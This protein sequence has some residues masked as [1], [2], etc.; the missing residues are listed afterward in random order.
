MQFFAK[1]TN[2]DFMGKRNAALIISIALMLASIVLLATRGLSFGLDFT[3]GTLI[4]AGYS[5]EADLS[6]LR[7][8]LAEAGY[9]D[10]VVQHFGTSRDVLVRVAPREGATTAEIGDAL[11]EVLRG[12]TDAQLDEARQDPAEMPLTIDDADEQFH[13]GP[14]GSD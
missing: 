1:Q 12:A 5:E 13:D 2:F 3:G 11:L 7:A 6:K 14:S 4:E 10:A 8:A 9:G